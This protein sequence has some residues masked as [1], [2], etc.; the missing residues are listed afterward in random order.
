ME[1]SESTAV[2]PA[3][4]ARLSWIQYLGLAD[5]TA[6]LREVFR[7]L[8]SDGEPFDAVAV[9]RWAEQH[10]WTSVQAT[11]ATVAAEQ[12]VLELGRIPGVTR[13]RGLGV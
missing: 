12:Q 2:S 5:D 1:D 10:G 11:N 4:A 8:R 13:D 6:A 9:G 7:A 3:V